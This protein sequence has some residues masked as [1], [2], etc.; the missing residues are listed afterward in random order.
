MLMDQ[1]LAAYMRPLWPW[2]PIANNFSLRTSRM[3]TPGAY[4]AIDIDIE[5]ALRAGQST[6]SSVPLK[7][8]GP[9]QPSQNGNTVEMDVERTK[10][11]EDSIM[12][13][14]A[15]ARIGGQYKD[16]AELL[17]ICPSQ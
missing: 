17:C 15:M 3:R 4:E 7:Y 16:M 5:E 2:V 11:I 6:V 12:Y 9:L 8:L 13:R 10:F 1:R 14:Y